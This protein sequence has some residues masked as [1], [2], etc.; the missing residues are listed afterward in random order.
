MHELQLWDVDAGTIDVAFAEI[1]RDCR[2][3][4]VSPLSSPRR[5][6]LPMRDPGEQHDFYICAT[7]GTQFHETVA[8]RNVKWAFNTSSRLSN[9]K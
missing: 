6:R 8:R 2:A 7:C 3:L 9:G 5:T 1:V 4:P